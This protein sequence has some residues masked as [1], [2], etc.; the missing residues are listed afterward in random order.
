MASIL[1]DSKSLYY[2]KRR[3]DAFTEVDNPREVRYSSDEVLTYQRFVGVLG[4]GE[5]G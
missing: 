3:V 2:L 1:A 4:D 5:R